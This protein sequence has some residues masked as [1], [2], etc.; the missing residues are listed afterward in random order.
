MD[1]TLV[2]AQAPPRALRVLL[3]EDDPGDA[4]L[5]TELL[6]DDPAAV[7]IEVVGTVALARRALLEAQDSGTRL[8]CVLLDLGLPD[9]QGLDAL[10]AV[11]EVAGRAAVLCLTGHADEHR[12]VAA[13]AAGAQDYL[14]KNQVDGPLLWRAIRYAIER[15]RADEQTRALY[16]SQARA[17]ENAR[18][19]RGLL[20]HPEVSDPSIRV[21]PRYRPG[22]E[23]V[24]G[25]DFYDV[26]ETDDGTLYLLIG[27]VA[28]HGPDEAALG[29]CLRI[30]WRT[31]VLSGRASDSLLPVLEDVLVRERR[32]DEVFA[33]VCMLVVDPDRRSAR[34]FL[35]GHPAP[36][37]LAGVP[38]QLPDEMVGPALGVLP[39]V[40]WGSRPVTL[41][42]GWRLVL[43]TDGI[44][45]G[46]VDEGSGRDSGR[47]RLGVPGLLTLAQAS[48]SYARSGELLDDLIAKARALHGGDLSDD[49]ALVLVEHAAEAG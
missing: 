12:G 25:G 27:D 23:A 11:L 29:V 4:F 21:T 36:L 6:A 31:L 41:E 10:R 22:R 28:G 48:P 19:E 1:E 7:V 43:F 5:V 15:K 49:V 44:V 34:M 38:E 16:L 33:T 37:L 46:H 47:D 13:A 26:V 40:V 17:A 42:P 18:L 9:A 24:L 14:A 8:D 30:A 3:V 39:G 35:A 20:P 2:V 32:S 45:E